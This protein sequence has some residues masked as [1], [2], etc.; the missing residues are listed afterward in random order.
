LYKSVTYGGFPADAFAELV[1]VDE[2]LL[3]TDAVLR[4][5][6]LHALLDVSGGAKRLGGAL[7]G[8]GVAVGALSH[9]L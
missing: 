3:D 7:E 5:E 6:G 4:H 1:E 2:E 9:V 8:A